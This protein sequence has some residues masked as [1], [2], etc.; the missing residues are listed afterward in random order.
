MDGI[1]SNMFLMA[2]T[3]QSPLDQP[4][5]S[6]SAMLRDAN[7]MPKA[8]TLQDPDMCGNS[9]FHR[10]PEPSTISM[11]ELFPSEMDQYE[12]DNWTAYDHS[13]GLRESPSFHDLSDSEETYVTIAFPRT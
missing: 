11:E 5:F 3:Q 9:S 4:F 7:A 8:N 13:L 12:I 6:F 2:A 10:I 1:N